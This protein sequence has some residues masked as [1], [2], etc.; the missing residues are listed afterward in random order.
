MRTLPVLFVLYLSLP[1]AFGFECFSCNTLIGDDDSKQCVDKREVCP[2]GVESC[3]TVAMQNR[4]D[5]KVHVRK[6]CTSPGTPI[7]QYLLFFPGS[8]LCQNIQMT[9]EGA[10]FQSQIQRAFNASTPILNTETDL[11][12]QSAMPPSIAPPTF[13]GANLVTDRGLASPPSSDDPLIRAK[14]VRKSPPQG[15]A[16]PPAPPNSHQSSL[17]CVCSSEM[18]NGGS[19]QDVLHRTVLSTLDNNAAT[20]NPSSS[21]KD[22]K[23]V[24]DKAKK[25]K[26]S[27]GFK[28]L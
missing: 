19:V 2:E 20:V 10:R 9:A 7:Y 14:R 8:S 12:V 4:E 24:A 28:Q 3:S 16:A 6:F 1:F 26:V 27:G 5:G 18:C 21:S 22:S 11:F 13:P 17:L 23:F 15:L 25:A